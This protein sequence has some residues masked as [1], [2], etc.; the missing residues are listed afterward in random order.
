MLQSEWEI[1]EKIGESAWS[2]NI[3]ADE[4]GKLGVFRKLK[5]GCSG[6]NLSHL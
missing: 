2:L 4:G 6:C 3:V 5:A 1:R